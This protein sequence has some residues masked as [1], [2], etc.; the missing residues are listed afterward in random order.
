MKYAGLVILLISF[1]A[2]SQTGIE[3]LAQSNERMKKLKSISYN[4][5]STN[6]YEKITADIVMKRGK[7]LP[8][9]GVAQIKASGI[10]ITDEGSKQITFAYNGSSFDF[11]DPNTHQMV[12]LDSPSYR[13]LGRTGVMTYTMTA[14]PAY[15]EK[16]FFGDLKRLTR[17]EVVGDTTIFGYSCYKINVAFEVNSDVAGKQLVN[18]SWYIGKEDKLFRG[19]SSSFSSHLI[20]IKSV[21][22]EVDDS[23]FSLAGQEE[24]KKM[25]GLEPIAE[26]LLTIG[27]KA[28]EWSLPAPGGK[29]ISLNALKGK[30]VLLDFW[31]TWCVPCLKAMPEIQAI[32]ER[33]KG[34]NV[35]IIGVSVEPEK[36][37]DPA[38]YMKKKNYTYALALD[39]K[40][41]TKEYKVSIY[42][43][44]YLIDKNGI[45]IHA[46]YGGNRE[47]FKEDLISR[48]EKALK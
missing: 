28:P 34:K 1:N 16:E 37:A 5:L 45:I 20:R 11:I 44:I 7:E 25:T 30:V 40:M 8:I 48:I 31:G 32:H 12:K 22:Q 15:W 18:V 17:A 26:G 35:E 10:A 24:I 46:E 33:F 39:G 14:L 9:F 4:I 27:S 2:H 6:P 19:I 41:I 3:I 13:K 36:A 29:T 47:N 42:P 38:A 43:T 21:D 23:V